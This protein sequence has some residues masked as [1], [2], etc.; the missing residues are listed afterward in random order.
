MSR[1]ELEAVY[2]DMIL[3]IYYDAILGHFERE[4]WRQDS[5]MS[6]YNHYRYKIIYCM[7][8]IFYNDY[9][10]NDNKIIIYME[11]FLNTVNLGIISYYY[12][13]I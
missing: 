11:V 12:V 6:L 1:Y 5:N 10:N 3:W 4:N 13:I 9:Y 7:C 2:H 8:K